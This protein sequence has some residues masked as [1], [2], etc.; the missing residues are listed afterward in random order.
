MYGRAE[1]L[2]LGGW[3]ESFVRS[4]RSCAKAATR[5]GSFSFDPA[6]SI[7]LRCERGIRCRIASLGNESAALESAG[8][9]FISASLNGLRNRATAIYDQE[10]SGHTT[11]P[12]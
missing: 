12:S 6:D 10:R 11:E 5:Q 8:V 9:E 1:L 2:S 4:F 3:A 7:F